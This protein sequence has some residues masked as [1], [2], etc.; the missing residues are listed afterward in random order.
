MPPWLSP[1]NCFNRECVRPLDTPWGRLYSVEHTK[2]RK[3]LK[4]VV[5]MHV[6][7]IKTLSLCS[8][9]VLAAAL[10]SSGC[11]G[12]IACAEDGCG[13]DISPGPTPCG[14]CE[15]EPWTPTN[16]SPEDLAELKNRSVFFAHNSVGQNI[17]DGLKTIEPSFASSFL[18]GGQQ[19]QN[20]KGIME[21]NMGDNGNPT[22]KLNRFVTLLN[23]GGNQT[24][25]ALFKFCYVDF[26][27]N[28][29]V[30][31][32]TT[33][34]QSALTDLQN[35]FPHVT[36]VHVTA[37]LYHHT[38]SYDNNV[39]ERFNGWLRSTYGNTVFDLAQLESVDSKGDT[40]LSRDGKTIAL[41]EEWSSGDGHLNAKG[42]QHVASAFIAFLAQLKLPPQ[43]Q[44]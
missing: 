33:A 6:L 21:H 22:A 13:A 42:S 18:K 26:D 10:L 9:A 39:R 44:L 38:S 15:E 12:C 3:I 4:E 37:P 27:R 16:H 19:P 36:F 14:D 8:I 35:R 30:D 43:S 29:Q 1:F 2:Y 7:A 28:T 32:L 25:I 23:N 31:A 40:A 17:I 41:A 20:A 11:I 5:A 34:Y 24:Q